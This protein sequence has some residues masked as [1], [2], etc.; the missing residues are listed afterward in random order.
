MC[1]C[2]IVVYTSFS[3][4]VRQGACT[5]DLFHCYAK[6]HVQSLSGILWLYKKSINGFPNKDA[7]Q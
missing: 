2:I 1:G 5:I 7:L 3:N 6:P 4:C